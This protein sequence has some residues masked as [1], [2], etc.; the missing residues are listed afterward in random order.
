LFMFLREEQQVFP[1]TWQAHS[2]DISEFP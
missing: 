1:I 2:K